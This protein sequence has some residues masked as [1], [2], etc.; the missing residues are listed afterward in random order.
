[1]QKSHKNTFSALRA[2]RAGPWERHNMEMFSTLLSLYMIDIKKGSQS[3]E[4]N[5]SVIGAFPS[6]RATDAELCCFTFPRYQMK[7]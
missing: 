6:Q 5:S 4:G 3:G 2:C 1:M 7:N